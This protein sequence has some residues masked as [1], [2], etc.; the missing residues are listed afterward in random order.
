M[1]EMTRITGDPLLLGIASNALG[2]PDKN[3][4]TEL[5]PQPRLMNL[6]ITSAKKNLWLLRCLI[7]VNIIGGGSIIIFLH[8]PTL[9]Q[10]FTKPFPSSR[11]QERVI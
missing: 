6:I 9:C 3:S 2:M 10:L 5:Y 7:M 4:T 8:P 1:A 11:E